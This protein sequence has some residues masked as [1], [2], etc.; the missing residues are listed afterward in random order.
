MARA[1]GKVETMGQA[2]PLLQNAE[3]RAE[4]AT[5]VFSTSATEADIEKL[6]GLPKKTTAALRQ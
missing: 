2:K 5:V 3:A 1:R 4:G 6:I